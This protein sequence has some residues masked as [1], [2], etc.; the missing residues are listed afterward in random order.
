M[1]VLLVGLGNPGA[2]Y[3]ST[4]HNTGFLFLDFLA[5]QLE[6]ASWKSQFEGLVAAV[7]S[8][9]L[10]R[11]ILLKPQ[12][13]MNASG[14]SVVACV[15]FF[16]LTPQQLVVFHDD[17]DVPV[18][19]YKVK[20]GG[21]HGGHNGLRDIHRALGTDAYLRVRLGIDRPNDKSLVRDYVL[22]TFSQL[23]Q[24]DLGHCFRNVFSKLGEILP[25]GAPES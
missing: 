19:V 12:T 18:G 11:L 16:K 24:D 6:V 5:E 20:K 17:L 3:A 14:R 21:S 9:D 23:E 15:N 10:G 22:S 13:F 25:K 2:E 8:P 1:P 4:R 7:H